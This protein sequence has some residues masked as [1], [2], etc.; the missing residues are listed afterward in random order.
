MVNVTEVPM[1]NTVFT[2]VQI[3]DGSGADAYAGEA[4]VQGIAQRDSA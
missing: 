2:N 1:P 3:L 4:L